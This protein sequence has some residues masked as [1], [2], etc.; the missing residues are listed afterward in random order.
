M[1]VCACLEKGTHG[2][3]GRDNRASLPDSLHRLML[4]AL[5]RIHDD[6]GSLVGVECALFEG[7]AR[8]ITA[9]GLRFE[10]SSAV[11]FELSLMTTH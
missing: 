11:F 4:D 1:A 2:S 6:G 7:D 8:F 10:S 5:A 9:F 3:W